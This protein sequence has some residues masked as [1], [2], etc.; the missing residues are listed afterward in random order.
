MGRVPPNP[1]Y[2]P[3]GP[4]GPPPGMGVAQP[5]PPPYPPPGVL[6]YPLG[7]PTFWLGVEGLVWWS[8]RQPLGVPVLTT[9][10]ASQGANAG[11][12][13]GARHDFAQRT[14]ELEHGCRAAHIRRRVV[15]L[16]S[17]H[18]HGRQLVLLATA[19]RQL[20]GHGPL[21]DRPICHQRAGQ[22]RPVFHS[23][24][25]RESKPAPR[26]STPPLDSAGETSTFFAT[27]IAEAR[28]P[29]ISSAAFATSN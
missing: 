18:R 8:Q 5:Y 25:A 9:G 28:G 14:V 6:A 7:N 16:Q 4:Y 11:N 22:R 20:R 17:H 29:S 13:G 26:P 1:V 3:P 12:L 10:P 21:G 24:S 2:P 19:D 15:R 23:G 27:S